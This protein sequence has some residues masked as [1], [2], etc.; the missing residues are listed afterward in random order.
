VWRSLAANP[1]KRLLGRISSPWVLDTSVHVGKLV[2]VEVDA[3]DPQRVRIDVS[4]PAG[5]RAVLNAPPKVTVNRSTWSPEAGW[6]GSAP[7][8][9]M[10]DQLKAVLE[11]AFQQDAGSAPVISG[12]ALLATGQRVPAM[13][14]SF[15]PTGTT[16]RS[17]GRTPSR[18]ELIDAPHYTL[19]VEMHF[20][21]LTPVTGRAV[22]PVPV[23]QVPSLSI[24]LQ[25]T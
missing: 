23:S 17:L 22:Q 7:S 3:D 5:P 18:P 24:G 6:S 19:E 20:P 15:A 16:P 8:G 4:Q 13:L 2:A 1:T 11:G 9:D 21:H 10:G 12:A 14:K 25:L